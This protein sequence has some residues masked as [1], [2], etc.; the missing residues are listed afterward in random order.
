[1]VMAYPLFLSIEELVD[2]VEHTNLQFTSRLI[3]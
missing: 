2:A 1:M 3:F